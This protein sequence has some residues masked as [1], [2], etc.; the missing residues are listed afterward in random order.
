MPSTGI[1]IFVYRGLTGKDYKKSRHASLFFHPIDE[2]A[3]TML[4]AAG[5]PLAFAV[6][7]KPAYDPLVSA[8]LAG[9]APVGQAERDITALVNIARQAPVN[10]MESGW[11]CQN[12]VGDA[13]RFLVN[14]GVISASE[15]SDA[16]DK[17]ADIILEA[18]DDQPF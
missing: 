2:I 15:R 9:E 18:A 1:K 3:G 17:M 4:H 7:T 5:L 13:L 6:E 14:A 10:N 8:T 12:W 16:L 11:N